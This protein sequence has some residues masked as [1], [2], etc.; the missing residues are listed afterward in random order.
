MLSIDAFEVN[1]TSFLANKF[2]GLGKFCLVANFMM[3]LV[4]IAF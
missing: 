4:I 3:L 2:N 1:L